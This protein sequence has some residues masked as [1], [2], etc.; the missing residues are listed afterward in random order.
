VDEGDIV[1]IHEGQ[2]AR[3]RVNALGDATRLSGKVI[4]VA[5][6][7]QKL[8]NE[9]TKSFR[10]RILISPRDDRLRPDMSAN[11]DIE[12]QNSPEDALRLASQAVVQKPRKE[13][14][15][16]ALAKATWLAAGAPKTGQA[17][18]TLR[19]EDTVDCV[20][21]VED[22]KAVLRPLQTGVSDGEF[23]EVKA[24]LDGTETVVIGPYRALEGLKP[25]DLVRPTK[26]DRAEP[27]PGAAPA[28]KGSGK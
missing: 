27:K 12:T 25:G 2:Q 4:E 3:I 26:K 22:G 6:R 7:A 5:N 16:A 15:D 13:V 19:A 23:V 20:F 17:S 18:L 1:K 24:G 8:T 9:E 14:P 11:V 28:E 10:V 21:V